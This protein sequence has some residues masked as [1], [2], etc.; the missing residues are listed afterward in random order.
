MGIVVIVLRAMA[1]VDGGTTVVIILTSTVITTEQITK[2]YIG[3]I[4]SV[5]WR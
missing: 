3:D 1:K 2:A 5:L 4:M